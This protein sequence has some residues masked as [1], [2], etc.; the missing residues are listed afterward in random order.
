M[1]ISSD[2]CAVYV[3]RTEPLA[4]A[5]LPVSILQHMAATTETISGVRETYVCFSASQPTLRDHK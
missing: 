3:I 4:L 5:Q 2:F 1:L